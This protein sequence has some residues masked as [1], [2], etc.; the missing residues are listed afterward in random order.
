MKKTVKKLLAAL[1]ITALIFSLAACTKSGKATVLWAD[2]LYQKDTTLGSGET[3]VAVEVQAEERSVTFTVKTDKATLGEA[4]LELGLIDG[5]Q[6]EY[7]LYVKI[8]N[9]MTADYDI[10]QSY[11]SFTKDGEMMMVGVDGAEIA[12]GEH[13]EL[14]YTK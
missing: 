14:I 10:D 3:T 12:D 2:A 1:L 13:Y 5:E 7:G 11:W 8:V 9:G 6:S 4:L